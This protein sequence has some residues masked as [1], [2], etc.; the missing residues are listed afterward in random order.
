MSDH[1]S[2]TFAALS[3]PTRRAI[4]ARLALGE[5]SVKE[6]AEPFSISAPSVTKHLKV[7][8]RA[9]LITRSR[10]AQWRPCR[11]AAAP[12]RDVSE[13]VE[14]YRKFWD[15][16]MNRLDDYLSKLQTKENKKHAHKSK[17]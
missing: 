6:L 15:Q 5:A 13:W 3:D 17:R 8:E 4:L 7:L 10:D 2:L 11:L 12:L 9:S 1:L 16:R 14:T